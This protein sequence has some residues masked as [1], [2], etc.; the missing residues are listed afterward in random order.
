LQG[1]RLDG[2]RLGLTEATRRPG[3]AGDLLLDFCGL[4]E[5]ERQKLRNR[6]ARD[7][8]RGEVDCARCGEPIWP[9]EPWDLGHV[10]GDKTRYA[11]PEH[12]ACN[13]ATATQKAKRRRRMQVAIVG[14]NSVTFIG[15]QMR[16]TTSRN[17]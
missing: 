14:E 17:W 8:V 7:V 2:G 9:E 5:G 12:R 1:F 13:R 10:D 15:E 3:R 6:W 11:G 4:V 16:R